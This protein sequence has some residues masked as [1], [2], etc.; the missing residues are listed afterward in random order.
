MLSAKNNELLTRVAT[1]TVM[2]SFFR[3]YWHPILLSSE[4]PEPDCAPLRVKVLGEDLLAFRDSEGKVGFVAERCPH[5]KASLF[6]GRVEEGG[7][8][9]SYH[10]WKFDRHGTCMDLPN[11][12]DESIRRKIHHKAYQ[13]YEKGGAIWI[14]MGDSKEAPPLPGL[15]WISLPSENL[16]Q[17]K[18]VQQSNWLQTMEGDIDQSHVG[19][20][21]RRLGLNS[22]NTNVDKIRLADLH[23]RMVAHD[24]PYGVLIGAGRE[25]AGNQRYWR[26]TQYLFPHWVMT[27]PYGENPNRH[28]RAWVPI[29]DTSTLLFT[30]TFNPLTALPDKDVEALKKGSGAGYVGQANFRAPTSEP[31]GAWFPKASMDND[32]FISREAQKTDHYTG[33]SEFWAQDAALQ[34]SMGAISDRSDEHLVTGDIGISRVRRRLLQIARDI[35]DNNTP[36][37]ATHDPDFYQ[38]RGAAALL[39]EDASWVDATEYQRKVIPGVNQAGL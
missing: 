24:M 30:V 16:Y 33:I 9:C 3:Q 7:I 19:F 5:R 14:Y 13:S 8:R 32:F 22:N 29:D 17:A 37:P 38:V 20:A 11:E 21:H 2:G 28:A 4:L 25:A 10:G 18:R 23:P 12:P 27:G 1:G 6:F 31:F 35:R 36:A 26:L 39:P 15:E 34:V